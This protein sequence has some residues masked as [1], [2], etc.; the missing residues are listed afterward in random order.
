MHVAK[1]L[2][3]LRNRVRCVEL[4]PWSHCGFLVCNKVRLAW[5]LPGS[6][7]K[8]SSMSTPRGPYKTCIITFSASSRI[9][10]TDPADL[11]HF[12][13]HACHLIDNI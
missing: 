1:D 10:N 12:W 7:E 4:F 6:D 8:W 2:V 11:S 3:S 9:T 13:A 5:S